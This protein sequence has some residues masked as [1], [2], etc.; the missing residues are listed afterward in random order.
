MKIIDANIPRK[1]EIVR[2]SIQYLKGS[3]IPLMSVVE[4]SNSGMCNR[5]CSFCP[6]SDPSYPDI[7]EFISNNLHTK[8]FLE[9]SELN[10]K[11]MII[12]SGFA[13]PL[14]HKKIY[15]N[16]SEAR[17]LLPEAKIELITNGDVLNLRRI[18]KLF[19]AGLST[20]LVSV[21]DGKKEEEKFYKL[22]EEAKLNNNQYVIRNRYLSSEDNFGLNL[23]N[24][25]GTLKNALYSVKPLQKSL[26]EKCNYPAYTFFIDYNGD[27][28]MC[29]H[30]WGKKYVLGN[31]KDQKIIDIW[32]NK[33]FTVARKNLLNKKRDF[34]PCNI[35]DVAGEL[36]GNDHANKW[37]PILK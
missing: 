19:D 5:K 20:L 16:I 33:K 8:I 29:S 32:C 18:K 13:E 12:Y 35:C 6:R 2:K 9:L 11:G 14:L 15:E 22:C 23:S 21:Y 10:Y 34:S 17:R 31:V 1:E 24:R 37:L 26:Q 3:K 4:I 27:V 28:L 25:S 36:I 7:N 30:D